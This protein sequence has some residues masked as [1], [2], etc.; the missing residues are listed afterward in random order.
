VLRAHTE[1]QLRAFGPGDLW[2][3][4]DQRSALVAAHLL[5]AQAPDGL[6][7][8]N[9]FDTVLQFKEYGEDYVVEPIA[10]EMLARDPALAKEFERR[11]AS[12][13]AFAASP[14]QR[15]DF[16][17]R[18]SPWADPDQ[19]LHPVARALRRPPPEVL[20]TR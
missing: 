15:S 4:L 14:F 9:A 17:Y 6:M 12:D 11:L 3:P 7:F 5:E 20:G 16:F 1:R 10:R 18:R 8:W 19:N 2:V 13:S